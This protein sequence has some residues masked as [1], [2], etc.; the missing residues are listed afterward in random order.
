MWNNI[1]NGELNSSV[2]TKLNNLGQYVEFTNSEKINLTVSSEDLNLEPSSLEGQIITIAFQNFVVPSQEIPIT[3]NSNTFE[4]DF[5]VPVGV[6]YSISLNDKLGFVTPATAGPFTATKFNT[7]NIELE[8]TILPEVQVPTG[9]TVVGTGTHL[10]NDEFQLSGANTILILGDIV[11]EGKWYFEINSTSFPA[12]EMPGVTQ[13]NTYNQVG[14]SGSVLLYGAGDL[15]VDYSVAGNYPPFN[16]G[17]GIRIG[18]LLDM[19]TRQVTFSTTGGVNILNRAL[20]RV[21]G[22]YKMMI[23]CGSTAARQFQIYRNPADFICV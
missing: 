18:V 16:Y 3:V 7:R 17:S 13:D 2:R 4:M 5:T 23:G 14:N 19:S 11:T 21:S 12:H 8:Y 1:E 15:Y 20:P 10:G 6:I 22:G 9:F